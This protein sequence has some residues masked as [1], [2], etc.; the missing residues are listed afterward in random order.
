MIAA[1][2]VPTRPAP[3]VGLMAA[4]ALV[5]LLVGC[6]R[7]PSGESASTPPRPNI[8]FI[9]IDTL[10]AD[11]LGAYGDPRNLS[12]TMDELA[13]EGVLF[14][15]AISVAPWTLPS[16]ASMF[17]GVNPTVH[18]AIDYELIESLRAR[19]TPR[20]SMFPDTFETLAE[21]LQAAGYQTA[22]FSANPFI[23]PE[24]GFAQ[25]FD[26]FDGSFAAN[27]T[28]GSVV[29][30]A[31]FRWLQGQRDPGRP[32]FLYL[33]YMDTHDP[34]RAAP[35]RLN[36][37]IEAVERKPDKRKLTPQEQKNHRNYFA[38][39]GLAFRDSMR[40]LALFEFADYWQARY[41]AGVAEVDVHIAALRDRLREMKLWDDSYVILTA[42]HG[43]S[44][45]EHRIWAHGLSA[46]QDQAHIPL[47]LRWPGAIPP[48][49]RV[50]DT[51]RSIDIAPTILE[52]LRLPP[53]RVCQGR[54][55]VKLLRGPAQG[56][57]LALIEGV[58]HQ[59]T[60][61]A[62]VH[63]RWKLIFALEKNELQLF[64]LSRDPSEQND[65]SSS[66][67][68]RVADLR[69]KLDAIAEENELLARDVVAQSADVSAEKL[70]QFGNVGYIGTTGDP[71]YDE[72]HEPDPDTPA[73]HPATS[74]SA[75][76]P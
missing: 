10:R 47:I 59:R 36:P 62:I 74:P 13:R 76:L 23:Q 53:L 18:K 22:A 17:S 46:H 16:M 28:A 29:N 52:Q 35:E 50:P 8:V 43:E 19:R 31:A 45:G 61:R 56:D 5:M 38:K 9:L 40:H 49:A 24:Y 20:V 4:V 54:S 37:L 44:L 72:P 68:E 21:S 41:D 51:V 12:P 33:H 42:D 30:D 73:S 70:R 63:G 14:E 67:P 32:F 11:R 66:Y 58:K 60:L 57:R 48:A 69:R 7:S 55:L 6:D 65:V 3:A 2:T 34:F 26:H 15:M 39:S 1:R 27:T 75:D 25:G 64:D 71:R